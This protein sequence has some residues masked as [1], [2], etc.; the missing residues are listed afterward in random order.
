MVVFAIVKA[1]G[2]AYK[3]PSLCQW[4]II[5]RETTVDVRLPQHSPM[6]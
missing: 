2:E 1:R 6:H 4:S 3:Y 5:P